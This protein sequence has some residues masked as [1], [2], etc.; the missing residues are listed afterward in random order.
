[1]PDWSRYY[2]GLQVFQQYTD[3]QPKMEKLLE[4]FFFHFKDALEC[5]ASLSVDTKETQALLASWRHTTV[6]WLDIGSGDG[7]FTKKAL[8]AFRMHNASPIAY[9]GL[10]THEDFVT[11]AQESREPSAENVKFILKDA[12]GGHLHRLGTFD[13]I[14]AF[15]ATYFARDLEGFKADLDKTLNLHAVA[16]FIQNRFATEKLGELLYGENTFHEYTASV[17]VQVF[18]PCLSELGWQLLENRATEIEI[19]CSFLPAGEKENVKLIKCLL[20]SMGGAAI[21]TDAGQEVLQKYKHRILSSDFGGTGNYA[22]ENILLAYFRQDAP[23]VLGNI[24]RSS[25][26]DLRKGS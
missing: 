21:E 12:F 24:V 6:Q 23:S 18:F 3:Q 7:S 25:L 17:I 26:L 14:T 1:M 10:D 13:L 2:R 15:N 16:L 8:N 5:M 19:A 11:F 22:S 4:G 9:T 20:E